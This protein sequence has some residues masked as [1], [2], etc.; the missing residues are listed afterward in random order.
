MPQI[1]SREKIESLVDSLL[2]DKQKVAAPVAVSPEKIFF[3]YLNSPKSMILD[4][5]A[6]P[7]NSVKEFFFPRHEV[8]YQFEKRGKDIVLQDAEPFTQ[9]QVVFGARL[10]DFAAIPI[11][12][13]VF[14]WDF[15]DRFFQDRLA[16]TTIVGIACSGGDDNC[17]CSSVG[18]SP[19]T[20][21]GA[22]AILIPIANGEFEVRTYTEKGKALFTGKTTES[23]K[24]GVFA[25]TP[26]IKFDAKKVQA[27]LTEQFDSPIWQQTSLR[28]VGCG[29]CTYFCPTC[30]CFDM[31]DDGNI[32]GAK[33]VKNW[34]S[35]QFALFTHHASG[36]NPRTDQSQRQRQRIQHKFRIYPE[37]FGAILCTGCGNCTRECSAS[38]GVR[39]V[40]ERISLEYTQL[41]NV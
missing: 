15:K 29:A 19:S 6:M 23:F 20:T 13:H 14:N 7:T 4:S 36:H 16:N 21:K 25:K 26:E 12:E 34:D 3:K 35:C 17:F 31:T 27:V 40:L 33:K 41:K 28:C 1:I 10:C 38:L 18:L 22:D 30:H 11:L 2:K 9:K 5:G 32:N 37:K 24:E 39:P 8:L